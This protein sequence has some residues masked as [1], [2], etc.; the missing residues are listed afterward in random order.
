M[1]EGDIAEMFRRIA[2]DV[3]PVTEDRFR[4]LC[5]GAGIEGVEPFFRSLLFGGWLARKSAER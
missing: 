2:S 5:A 4:Q 3:H 1:P